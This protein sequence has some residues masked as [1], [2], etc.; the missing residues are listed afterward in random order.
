MIT[1]YNRKK[2]VKMEYTKESLANKAIAKQNILRALKDDFPEDILEKLATVF[3][4]VTE[5][6]TFRGKQ[7]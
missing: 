4:N 5:G 3:D 1:Y 6:Y 7:E 2:E